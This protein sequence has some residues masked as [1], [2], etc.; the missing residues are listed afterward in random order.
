MVYQ[1]LCG[2]KST[3]N[4]PWTSFSL[5]KNANDENSTHSLLRNIQSLIF[6]IRLSSTIQK[7]L[8]IRSGSL[9]CL[10]THANSKPEDLEIQNL[11]AANVPLTLMPWTMR[12]ASEHGLTRD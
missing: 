6:S 1:T 5:A 7:A 8:P 9:A 3:A 12:S 11:T 2:V 4:R 10:K